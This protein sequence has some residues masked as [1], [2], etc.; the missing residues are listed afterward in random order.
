M[1]VDELLNCKNCGAVLPAS[2][3]QTIKCQYCS[4]VYNKQQPEV[5]IPGYTETEFGTVT[6]QIRQIDFGDEKVEQEFLR[7]SQRINSESKEADKTFFRDRRIKGDKR[8][9]TAARVI[10]I[11]VLVFFAWIIVKIVKHWGND[12]GKPKANTETVNSSKSPVKSQ[13]IKKAEPLTNA[14]LAALHKLSN[15]KVDKAEFNKLY[16]DSVLNLHE[17]TLNQDIVQDKSSIA[18]TP[19]TGVYLGV[20]HNYSASLILYTQRVGKDPLSVQ[21]VTFIVK[22]KPKLLI[23]TFDADYTSYSSQNLVREHCLIFI[24]DEGLSML[25]KLATAKKVTIRFNG[26]E[27]DDE[28][29][30]P[31]YQQK[32][33]LRQLKLYK[34]LLLQ[35]DKQ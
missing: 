31:D 18:N 8:N 21:S 9:E 13:E 24:D 7:N 4:T 10:V 30:L 20:D 32:S 1:A 33:L 26:S 28:I 12:S 19:V 3:G 15:I 34:G 27:G 2:T 5:V 29:I 35:Y 17:P 6:V 23:P 14:D 22:G 16:K 25:I 11:C